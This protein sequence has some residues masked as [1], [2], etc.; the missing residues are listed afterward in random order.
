[1]LNIRNIETLPNNAFIKAFQKDFPQ[2]FYK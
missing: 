1:M 2:M